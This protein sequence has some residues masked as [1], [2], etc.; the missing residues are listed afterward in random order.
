VVGGLTAGV[1]LITVASAT[2]A[3]STCEVFCVDKGETQTLGVLIALV[4]VT[5]LLVGIHK[6]SNE[7]QAE[8]RIAAMQ[9]PP[10]PGPPPPV[11]H[12][13]AADITYTDPSQRQFALQAS[14]AA[15]RGDCPA[16]R[17]AGRRLPKDIERSLIA[18]D[19]AYARC[20]H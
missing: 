14:F 19:P 7:Q 2:E 9:P 4:G 5:T 10:R 18:V 6:R 11:V 13:P 1:G 20:L 17:A 12:L 8:A 15:K 3:P 16:A